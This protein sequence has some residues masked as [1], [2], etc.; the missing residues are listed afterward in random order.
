MIDFYIRELSVT[1]IDV[2]P[3]VLNFKR[4]TNIIYGNSDSG[5]SY[6]AE[7]LDF[8]FGAKTMR[9]KSD[10]GYDTVK[11]IIET[12]QGEITLSRRFDIRKSTVEISS[13]D[14]RFI[15]LRCTGAERDVLESFW[16]RLIGI[17]ENQTIVTSGYFAHEML[18]WNNIEKFL[19]LK[20]DRISSVKSVI[21]KD[22]K[23]LSALL[24][25]LTGDDF[26]NMS[27]LET[28][29]DRYKRAKGAKEQIRKEMESVSRRRFELLE[30]LTSD[31]A[32]QVQQNWEKIMERLTFE[33]QQLQGSISESKK[34]HKELDKAQK[35][36]SSLMLQSEN[37]NL[38][39]SLYAAQ[40]KRLAFTLEGQLLSTV[41]GDKC[42]CPFCG[43]ETETKNIDSAAL[44]ATRA[45][46]EDAETAIH[47]FQSA[48]EELSDRIDKQHALVD[49]LRS[50]CDILDARISETYA[51]SVADL[52]R[53][54]SKYLDFI[55]M[56]HEADLLGVDYGT[57]QT[58]YD[59][60][61]QKP[62]DE[63]VKYK[64]KDEY[65]GSFRKDMGTRMEEMLLAC[66]LRNLENVRFEMQTMDISLEWQDKDTFGEGYRAFLNTV[67]AFS[68]FRH[69][70]ETG[71]YVPGMLILDS[72]IQAMK[73]PDGS[74][75]TG[76]LFDYMIENSECGQVFIIE[77]KLPDSFKA[78][79]ATVYSLSENGF[80]PDFKH[81]IKKRNDPEPIEAQIN[82]DSK[83]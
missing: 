21:P 42:T 24:F 4:G 73:Q 55:R 9:L 16:L 57:L 69:L 81:P 23:S 41:H 75:L 53:Q 78:E 45:E 65:P 26:A 66:G 83:T 39:R 77:N 54:M 35:I 36:L 82:E 79:K 80:L 5:K 11:A 48:S 18:T 25:L 44:E 34:L 67:V 49:E 61:D 58:E 3:S 46:F 22:F 72:P 59:S 52:K 71:K 70:C 68:L 19:L 63:A 28:D 51:P 27:A 30:K 64:P 7:C 2:R 17:N 37:H 6:V 13:T 10:S 15:G 12:S 38:L 56:Q 43:K 40:A 50:K 29:K 74:P 60:W 8:I 47:Q 62:T 32:Q 76:L 33:E 14:P 1:G 31:D 20:E